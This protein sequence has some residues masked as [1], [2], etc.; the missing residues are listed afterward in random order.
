LRTR[1]YG[2]IWAFLIAS[3]AV[4]APARKLATAVTALLCAGLGCARPTEVELRL[5]PC[6]DLTPVRVILD[7]QG[8]DAGGAALAPLHAEFDIAGAGVLA[9][10]FATVGLRKPDGIAEADFTLTWRDA[11]GVAE[12]VTHERL[13]VPEVGAVLEL[14]AD[15]CAPVDAT[16]SSGD[17]ST[18]ADPSTGDSTTGDASSSSSTT[19]PTTGTTGGTS[20]TGDTTTTGDSTTSTST[21]DTTTGDMT[22]G[23]PSKLGDKCGGDDLLL[24]E[25]FGPGKMGTALLCDGEFWEVA[26]LVSIC[27]PLSDYCPTG[28]MMMP[29]PIGCTAHEDG[30]SGFSCV[31]E[32]EP[33]VPCLP[34][35]IGCEGNNEITLCVDDGEGGEQQLKGLCVGQCYDVANAPYCIPD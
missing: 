8:Y 3:R 20:S 9:D 19:D 28:K 16:S 4:S 2:P 13:A 12:V 5:Y 24:C 7:V 10:G 23:E 18:T 33:K 26:N 22:T 29:K 30:V 14:G 21:T 31:C 34:A 32:E 15:G 25:H 27:S 11:G 35:M 6:A 17:D 1:G